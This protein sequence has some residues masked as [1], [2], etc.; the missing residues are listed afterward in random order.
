MDTD[1]M[2][3]MES[4]VSPEWAAKEAQMLTMQNLLS[5]EDFRAWRVRE[6]A[7]FHQIAFA[8]WGTP[9]PP[10]LRSAFEP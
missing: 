1:A 10:E 2:L 3:L 9:L 4:L 5:P 7:V 6:A 8:W